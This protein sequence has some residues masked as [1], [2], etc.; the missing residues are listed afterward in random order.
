MSKVAARPTQLQDGFNEQ[1][2]CGFGGPRCCDI[3]CDTFSSSSIAEIAS[4]GIISKYMAAPVRHPLLLGRGRLPW[5][6][7]MA[8]D[9]SHLQG[10]AATAR[11]DG[12]G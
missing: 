9:D 7:N 3:S 4:S 1:R 10:R 5:A 12:L 2:R 8:Q 11:D 6:P